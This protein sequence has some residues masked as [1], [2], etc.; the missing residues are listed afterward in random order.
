MIDQFYSF[1]KTDK[2]CIIEE[3]FFWLLETYFHSSLFT[4]CTRIKLVSSQKKKCKVSE[5]FPSQIDNLPGW[6]E[7]EKYTVV[8]VKW[9]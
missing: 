6:K 4:Y 3:S 5:F 2:A 8:K 1:C 7:I 9:L